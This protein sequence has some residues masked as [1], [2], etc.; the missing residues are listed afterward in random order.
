[1]QG[2][3]KVKGRFG[4]VRSIGVARPYRDVILE[5]FLAAAYSYLTGK[6]VEACV[7]RASAC[8]T[9]PDAVCDYFQGWRALGRTPTRA[10]NNK[11]IC[12]DLP[13]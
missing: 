12:Y 9:L 4:R 3:H 10:V 7:F 11:P 1:M 2:S 5:T 8:L 13:G 6:P